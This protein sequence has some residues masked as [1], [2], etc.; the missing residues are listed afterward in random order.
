MDKLVWSRMPYHVHTLDHGNPRR[1]TSRAIN[2]RTAGQRPPT[3][4]N[5]MCMSHSVRSRALLELLNHCRDD[6]RSLDTSVRP[7]ITPPIMYKEIL[8]Q[9]DD[10]TVFVVDIPTSIS[11]NQEF[12][13]HHRFNTLASCPP[14]SKPY[15]SVEPKGARARENV[16]RHIPDDVNDAEVA[17]VL[18]AALAKSRGF[19]GKDCI[20]CLPRRVVPTTDS[21]RIRAK[22]KASC[23]PD[24]VGKPGGETMIS[25]Q[26]ALENCLRE[27]PMDQKNR[28]R[29]DD[30]DMIL[31]AASK[32]DSE[33]QIPRIEQEEQD[34]DKS[35][36][37][38]R[39]SS[40]PDLECGKG[41]AHLHNNADKSVQLT[42]IKDDCPPPNRLVF[43][44]PP[45]CAFLLS[46]CSEVTTFRSATRSFLAARRSCKFDFALLDPPWPNRSVIRSSSYAVQSNMR[47]IQSLLLRMDLDVQVRPG[48]YL[49]VWITNKPAVRECVLGHGGLFEK[50]NVAFQEEWTWLK[51]TESGEPVSEIEGSW[52]KPYETCLFGKKPEDEFTVAE[53]QNPVTRRVIIAVPDLHSRKPNLKNVVKSCFMPH[54]E[55][56]LEVFARHL[57]ADWFCWGN[58]ALKFNGD[59]F[60][61]LVGTASDSKQSGDA[62]VTK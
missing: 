7:I 52:R 48:G 3:M 39:E 21:P 17:A 32:S 30:E 19:L 45:R 51:V 8:Y 38:T 13:P 18:S 25:Q 53:H 27:L 47:S 16:R 58:E 23:G 1:R 55:R 57:T 35:A 24:A 49:A 44:I 42:I 50:W 60:W 15:L 33:Y 9:S 14:I 41:F 5:H 12:T 22:R 11:A 28:Y 4:V 26:S 43:N 31:D 10:S 56:G 59:C 6:R 37:H 62:V 46:D 61:L 29:V 36:F 40:Q 20:F 2:W 54:M 34:I